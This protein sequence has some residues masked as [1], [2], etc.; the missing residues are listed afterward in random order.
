MSLRILA[1]CAGNICR[2]P[3]AAAAIAAAA[4]AA[5]LDVE[6]DSAGTGAWNL[7]ESP[8]PGAVAAARAAGLEPQGKA[9][10]VHSR[11]FERYDVI[12]AMD[13]SN[14][15]DLHAIAPSLE[16]KAK[17]RLFATY[18]QGA[19]LEEIADPYGGPEEGYTRMVETI[20]PAASGLVDSLLATVRQDPVTGE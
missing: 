12:V 4:A 15:A 20:L 9:R 1:V 18:D 10:R 3:T 13:R 14:L 7:G 19:E 5:G 6:V 16:A 2:S 17:V 8:H 11:D